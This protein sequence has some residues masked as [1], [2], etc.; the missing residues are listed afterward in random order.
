[1]WTILT[2]VFLCI[3][4]SPGFG[5]GG[6]G[7]AGREKETLLEFLYYIVGS[8]VPLFVGT[9]IALLRG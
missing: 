1:M 4:Y 9:A 6:R 3:S 5:G 8:E 7:V 2:E